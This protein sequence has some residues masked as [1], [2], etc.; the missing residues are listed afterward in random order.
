M[1]KEGW[2]MKRGINTFVFFLV[3]KRLKVNVLPYASSV[4]GI[5]DIAARSLFSGGA[6]G[7]TGGMCLPH[8]SPE[9]IF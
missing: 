1:V 9:S 5:M 2:V 8:S 4:T 3:I 7:G 6:T